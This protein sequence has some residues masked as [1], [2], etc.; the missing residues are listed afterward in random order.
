MRGIA[1]LAV[2]LDHCIFSN[3]PA[4]SFPGLYRLSGWLISGVDLFFVLSGF[5]IGGILLDHKNTTNYFRVF[6]TRRVGRIMPVYYLL[7]ATFF[8]VLLI[9][10]WLPAPWLDAFLLKD[11]MPVWTY[12]LFVQNI[13]QALDGGDGGA[14]WVAS[15]WSLGIEEQFYLL[16]PPLI[17]I[18]SVV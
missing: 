14:R 15:T 2:L 12:P 8:T 6:W 18:L 10:P 1:C 13:A 16:L 11:M 7:L 5:L 17:Y 3:I 4:G 9:R